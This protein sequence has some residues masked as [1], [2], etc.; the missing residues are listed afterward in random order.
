M[1]LFDDFK[2]VSHEDWLQKITTDLKGKN[3]NDTLVWDSFEGI[4]VQPFYD[5]TSLND[6]VAVKSTV[7]KKK[8]WL[9]R[10]SIIISTPREANQK[11]LS[12][13]KGGANALLFIGDINNGEEMEILLKDILI[14]IIDLNFYT[15]QPQKV[16]E[17]LG[18]KIDKGSVSYDYLGE[19]LIHG[20]W[21]KNQQN[22]ISALI[23]TVN[24]AK[25]VK[26][27]S[28]NGLNYSNAGS[29]I[30]QELAFS[31]AQGVEYFNLLTDQGISAERIAS[32][33]Q[34]SFGISS[35]YF[36]EIAKLRAARILWK[37]I[38]KQYHVSEDCSMFIHTE[39]SNWN[40][41]SL[42]AHVNMLRA[43]TESMSAII[44]GCNSL[45]VTP[46]NATYEETS[47]FSERIAR[48]TQIVLKEEAFLD[49]VNNPSDGSYYIEQLT[50]E[51]AEKSWK[52]FQ[53]I[54]QKGGFLSCIE[55]S[56]IQ[57]EIKEVA[58][59]KNDAIKNGKIV[60]VGANKYINQKET[61]K[62]HI[63]ST[64]NKNY[65]TLITPLKIYRAEQEIEALKKQSSNVE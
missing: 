62:E 42:D 44:G 52:L 51:I 13:L 57:Q 61:A 38:L 56:W 29:T 7:S 31:L 41:T 40:L 45:T 39:T 10:E 16:L 65:S 17:L 43:T 2:S 48:N 49:K 21:K 60:L 58:A 24:I 22:D 63:S 19:F 11:A 55:N 36:F 20:N 23:Q 30:V 50:D 3:F 9:I 53:E 35:N 27:I 47:D 14:D 15:S 5:K 59:K 4:S 32:S 64:T 54:E 1:G 46:Y 28:I 33:I 25:Q 12:A 18:N 26:T 6:S 34:F 37:M 8:G